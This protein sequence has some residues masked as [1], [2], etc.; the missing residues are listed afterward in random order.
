MCVFCDH[1]LRTK[2]DLSS[3]ILKCPNHNTLLHQQPQQPQQ[4]PQVQPQ[5]IN[6]ITNDHSVNDNS[7]NTTVNNKITNIANIAILNFGN[8]DLSHI[9]SSALR[10]CYLNPHASIPKLVEYVHFN[11]AHPENKNIKLDGNDDKHVKIYDGNKWNYLKMKP[12]LENIA[13]KNFAILEKRVDEC[14]DNMTFRAKEKW[15]DFYYGYLG[16]EPL[17]LNTVHD[18]LGVLLKK[19]IDK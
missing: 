19:H 13:N 7:I 5:T 17:V 3:H 14:L 10:Q 9:T 18:G 6:N 4:Q 1:Y 16:D 8:E 15:D 11:T 2:N 12:A